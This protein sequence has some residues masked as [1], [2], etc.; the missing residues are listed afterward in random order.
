MWI[1][2]AVAAVVCLVL[3]GRTVLAVDRGD[4]AGQAFVEAL[5]RDADRLDPPVLLSRLAPFAWDHVSVIPPYDT[6]ARFRRELVG[7]D[8]DEL[9]ETGDDELVL[10]FIRDQRLAGWALLDDVADR[11]LGVGT[12]CLYA[13]DPL[14]RGTTFL[15][16]R[17][18]RLYFSSRTGRPLMGT[19]YRGCVL[20]SP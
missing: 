7:V 13:Y 8:A 16:A 14:E 20:A 19:P 10:V 3:A 6:T 1:G 5:D 11:R 18:D 15:T 17:N 12:S 9:P 2:F 4:D